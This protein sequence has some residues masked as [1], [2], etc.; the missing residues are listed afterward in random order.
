MDCW[1]PYNSI[2]VKVVVINSVDVHT[3]W[4]HQLFAIF[5]TYMYQ[6]I[7]VLFGQATYL[8]HYLTD[9][10]ELQDALFASLE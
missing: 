7:A 1:N 4:R 6:A 9:F 5:D 2:D 3:S 10:L 8:D